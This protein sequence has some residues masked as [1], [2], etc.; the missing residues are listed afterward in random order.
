MADRFKVPTVEVMY[1]SYMRFSGQIT[2]LC[3]HISNMYILYM[4]VLISF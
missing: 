2:F 4:C 1:H 3:V